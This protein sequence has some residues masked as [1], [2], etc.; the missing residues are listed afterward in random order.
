MTLRLHRILSFFAAML[1]AACIA[2]PARAQAPATT[3]DTKSTA[4]PMAV[5]D[6][7]TSIINARKVSGAALGDIHRTRGFAYI[8]NK[9][10][11]FAKQDFD[12]AIKFNPNDAN[13]YGMRAVVHYTGKQYDLALADY[14][15]VLQKAPTNHAAYNL[16]G[17]VYLDKGMHARAVQD[18]DQ[19]LKLQPNNP[20]YTMNKSRA[21]LRQI[22][23]NQDALKEQGVSPA[24]L[25]PP[26]N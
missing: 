10:Y 9:N 18:F 16:R 2:V 1:I 21:L 17:K 15:V 22:K 5:A 26:K 12:Q 19:A 23:Q 11:A 25:D 4:P 6:A 24:K 14:N 3:C 7:C 8:R 13:A 20:E